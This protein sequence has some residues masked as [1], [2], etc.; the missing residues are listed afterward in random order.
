ML[1]L[2]STSVCD[3]FGQGRVLCHVVV[4]DI[5]QTANHQVVELG[6]AVQAATLAHCIGRSSEGHVGAVDRPFLK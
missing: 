2:R 3:L 5:F 1:P 4:L 6:E